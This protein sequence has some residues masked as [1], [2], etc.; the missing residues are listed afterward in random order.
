MDEVSEMLAMDDILER[1]SKGFAGPAHQGR[2]RA[3]AA[4]RPRH[5]LLDEP[6]R[7]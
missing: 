6:T 4:R 3:R 5:L 1:R 2:P 7:T